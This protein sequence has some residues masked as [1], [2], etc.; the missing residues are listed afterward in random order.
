MKK[1]LYIILLT[2]AVSCIPFTDNSD[3]KTTSKKSSK[4]D[5]VNKTFYSNGKLRSEV[6]IRDGKKNG[7][8]RDF[9]QNGKTHLE[10][11]YVNSVKH[12]ITRM[13]YENGNLYQES[14]YENGKI[15]GVQKKFREDGRLMAEVPYRNGEICMGLKEYL[16]DGSLKKNYPTIVVTPI[17]NILKEDRYTLRL[18]MSDK[19]KNVVFYQGNL[20]D[21]C[22]MD[23]LERVYETPVKGVSE[24]IYYL[25]PGQFL[26]EQINIIAKVKTPLGN[27]YVTQRKY[28]VAIEHR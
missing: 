1:T 5:G 12:G 9:Y 14:P 16:T 24:I 26:M 15:N 17:D 28:N 7:T 20:S 8:A 3:E 21:N 23:G 25:M 13:Y 18:T 11:E 4:K 10:I 27:E 6:P 2:V 19:S 22:L